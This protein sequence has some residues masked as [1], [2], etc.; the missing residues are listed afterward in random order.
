MVLM[1]VF[2]AVAALMLT[3]SAGWTLPR[4]SRFREV[5]SRFGD[6][7]SWFAL[8]SIGH[9]PLKAYTFIAGIF[10]FGQNFPV[11]SRLSGK[12]AALWRRVRPVADRAD[13]REE[14]RYRFARQA[15]GD[16]DEP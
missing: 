16:K 4:N 1:L 8:P 2:A 6:A 12:L 3:A 11:I 9:N 7:N 10:G 13:G 15:A 5:N 14:L